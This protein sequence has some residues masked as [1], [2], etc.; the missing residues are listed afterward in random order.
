MMG[1]CSKIDS[2]GIKV[3]FTPKSVKDDGS[4]SLT[5]QEFY[6][7][8][9]SGGTVPGQKNVDLTSEEFSGLMESGGWSY[10]E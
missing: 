6:G 3:F 10:V 9:R 7:L 5:A 4:V 2:R 1:T 8:I